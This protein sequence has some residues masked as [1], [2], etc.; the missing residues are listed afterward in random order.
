MKKNRFMIPLIMIMLLMITK[1]FVSFSEAAL[2]VRT[3]A[4][5]KD[6]PE[7]RYPHS[8]LL[9]K[10]EI[11]A[12]LDSA[13]H[14]VFPDE[15]QVEGDWTRGGVNRAIDTLMAEPKVDVIITLGYLASHEIAKRKNLPKPVIAPLVID[16]TVQN[17]P[18]KQNSSGIKNLC[19]IDSFRSVA[20]NVSVFREIAKINHV[21]LL[22][23]EIFISEIP[24]IAF[25][26]KEIE[27]ETK[28]TIHVIGI[29]KNGDVA[30]RISDNTHA[31]IFG[32]LLQV[33]SEEFT[34]IIDYVNGRKIPSFSLVGIDDVKRGV[35]ASN[36]P[37]SYSQHLARSTAISVLDILS[38]EKAEDLNVTFPT[39]EQLSINMETA[40]LIDVYPNW[41]VLTEA[42][43]I[44]QSDTERGREV[45]MFQTIQDALSANL[46]LSSARRG[47]KAGEEAVK[48][49]RGPLLPNVS[50]HSA[51]TVI[52]EEHAEMSMGMNPEQEWTGSAR[53]YQQIYSE[54]AWSAYTAEKH[55][56]RSR[57]E[58]MKTMELDTIHQASLAYLNVLRMKTIEKI[59]MNN[60]KL[61]RANLERAR[62]REAIGAAGPDEVYRWE[63]EIS[64]SR[65]LVL[66]AVAITLQAEGVL[67]KLVHKPVSEKLSPNQ[68]EILDPLGLLVDKRIFTYIAN[69]KD[70]RLYREFVTGVGIDVSPELAG[71]EAQ[72]EA[73]NRLH[74]ASKR[75][76]WMPTFSLQGN[77]TE[78]LAEDG[79]ASDISSTDETQWGAGVFLDFPLFRGG[80]KPATS[81]RNLEELEQLRLKK[82]SVTESVEQRIF[83]ETQDLVST[84]PGIR[85]SRDAAEAAGKNL[86][87]VTSSYSRGVK[88]IIDLLDAQNLA[89]VA[90]QQVANA[91]YDFIIDLLDIHR[92]A[93]SF[94]PVLDKSEAD[95]WYGNLKVYFQENY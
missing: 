24:E 31:V 17:L 49:K 68:D 69:P 5:V 91:H 89:L 77:V 28:V 75:D 1:P 44:N 34:R 8:T 26:I 21:T 56:H 16:R 7:S 39:V 94:K 27:K 42:N 82:D 55:L 3:I 53:L 93:G 13:F 83:R 62:T 30:G 48:Q 84:Y 46:D 73:K 90:D 63:S 11:A 12:M 65:K 38:G 79:A 67:N 9:F 23:D 4:I 74:T 81:R 19:Y 20:K 37:D 32:P 45:S 43:L 6:G 15:Y 52:D 22:M 78:R 25:H 71:L 95:L 35:L 29:Q 10:Q 61:T 33:H 64:K 14:A 87:L 50:L 88:S 72:L 70:M 80:S 59:H 18:F 40:R 57:V 92:S 47:V 66:D 85:L 58:S 86:E 2:P 41:R 36:Q 54:K 76:F 60:L 51:A